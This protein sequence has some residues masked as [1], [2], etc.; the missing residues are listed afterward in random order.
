MVH[1]LKN[2]CQTQSF[3]ER[4]SDLYGS[5]CSIEEQQKRYE[6]LIETHLS[7]L[8]DTT[9]GES[10]LFS[11]SGRTELGGNHT[12]HN[13]GKVIAGSINLDTIAVASTIS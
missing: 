2:I 11:T 4:L 9:V 1:R 12:D 13:H 6:Q 7:Y 10:A 8:G 3:K 5:S